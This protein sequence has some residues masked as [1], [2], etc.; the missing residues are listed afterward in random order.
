MPEVLAR[1]ASARGGG[2]PPAIAAGPI[3]Q[4]CAVQGGGPMYGAGRD[5]VRHAFLAGSVWARPDAVRV[6]AWH[7]Y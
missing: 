4:P 5:A 6:I 2:Q 3:G 1:Q 7:I